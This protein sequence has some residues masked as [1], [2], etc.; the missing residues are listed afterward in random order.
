MGKRIMKCCALAATGAMV[1]QFGGCL[2][3]IWKVYGQS[4]IG[5]SGWETGRDLT[6]TY[7]LAGI[8]NT[9]D[10]VNTVN[11]EEAVAAE[12]AARAGN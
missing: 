3:N 7:L 6:Q 1:F 12:R 5:G 8:T 4:V 9:Q 2:G 10:A 11:F